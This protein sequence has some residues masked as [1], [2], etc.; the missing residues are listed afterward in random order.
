MAAEKIDHL[1]APAGS[2]ISLRPDLAVP[3]RYS[4]VDKKEEML[5]IEL[6]TARGSL[7]M[8]EL[9]IAWGLHRLVGEITVEVD[10]SLPPGVPKFKVSDPKQ[11][12]T[13]SS[14]LKYEQIRA[15]A[16]AYPAATDKVKVHYTGWT[17]DGEMVDS[18]HRRGQPASFKL[19]RVIK[20]WTEGLQL[21]QPGA[22]YQFTIPPELAY[23]KRGV[24]KI[25]ADAT[26]VFLVTLIGIE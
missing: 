6:K 13:T 20:G 11:L 12:I 25:P 8:A 17:V 16:G 4:K 2:T 1:G 7:D 19:N 15:G 14:G 22:T 23:G 21:M 3:M 26:L 9:T 5:R 24:G 10:V 18:S